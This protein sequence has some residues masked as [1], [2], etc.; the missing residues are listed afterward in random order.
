MMG[1]SIEDNDLT[2]DKSIANGKSHTA[3]KSLADTKSITENKGLIAKK[4]LTAYNILN[5]LKFQ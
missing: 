1:V 3:N 2:D 5:D 4:S